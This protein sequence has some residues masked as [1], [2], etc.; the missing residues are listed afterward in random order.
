[1]L[2]HDKVQPTTTPPTTSGRAELAPDLLEVYPNVLHRG[3]IH[4]CI[5]LIVTLITHIELFRGEWPTTNAGC[6]R[7]HY[8]DD[9]S[10][11][12]WRNAEA[13]ADTTD[14]R[15]TA[16]HERIRPKVDVKHQ[17]VRA[18]DEDALACGQRLVHIYDAVN[19]EGT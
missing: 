18:F 9:F 16:C 13:G 17:R 19:D 5:S 4:E 8:T 11:P 1:M 3:N 6:V 15:R 14:G 10:D 7:F 2:H 12:T